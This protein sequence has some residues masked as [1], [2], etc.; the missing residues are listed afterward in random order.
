MIKSVRRM[1]G[2]QESCL[3]TC[4]LE[5]AWRRGIGGTQVAD[6]ITL[7][8]RSCFKSTNKSRRMFCRLI[9]SSNSKTRHLF[10]TG[11]PAVLE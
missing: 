9:G 3:A 8:L 11:H 7:S 2:I 5:D 4:D 1:D 10:Y 6:F